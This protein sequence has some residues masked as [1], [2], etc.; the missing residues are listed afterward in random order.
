MDDVDADQDGGVFAFDVSQALAKIIVR[1][2]LPD[3]VPDAS[4]NQAEL[5][6]SLNVTV[7]TVGKFV[8]QSV[9]SEAWENER[10]FP[11]IQQGGMGRAY[12]IKLSHAFAWR[13]YRAAL[14][15]GRAQKNRAAIEAMQAHF[16]GMDPDRQPGE[17]LDPKTR[18]AMAEADILHNKAAMLRRK[19]VEL[20]EV[21]EL[22]ESV[23]GIVRD[24]IEGMPDRLERELGLKPEQ[25]SQV[26]RIGDDILRG[27]V[28]KVEEA[29]LRERDLIDDGAHEQLTF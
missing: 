8:S 5:A 27:I 17:V 21:T 11:V 26:V 14:E 24:G 18:R 9:L 19:L 22:L 20:G 15:T 4:M 12:V 7:N 28:E 29:E 1:F 6:A 13:E 10:Q 16:Y 2:P 25:V 3:G 23:F